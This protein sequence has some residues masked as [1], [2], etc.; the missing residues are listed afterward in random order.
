MSW[1]AYL[2]AYRTGELSRRIHQELRTLE[3]RTVCPRDCGVDRLADELELYHTGRHARV[4]T[5][6]AHFGEEDCLRSWAGSGTIFDRPLR[7]EEFERALSLTRE[8]GLRVDVR[9]PHP[10]LRSSLRIFE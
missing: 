1:P 3:R 2:D 10:R 8:A 6:F 9:A 5:R 4:S 7:R